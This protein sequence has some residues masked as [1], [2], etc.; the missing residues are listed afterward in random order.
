M[1]LSF[2]QRVACRV[3][4]AALHAYECPRQRQCETAFRRLGRAKKSAFWSGEARS[5]QPPVRGI[6]TGAGRLRWWSGLANRYRRRKREVPPQ[7]LGNGV[8]LQRKGTSF[9]DI[10]QEVPRGRKIYRAARVVRMGVDVDCMHYETVPTFGMFGDKKC[11]GVL[12]VCRPP[13]RKVRPK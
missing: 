12:P 6:R 4:I 9:E 10:P 11:E 13:E 2:N 3:V 1:Q 5:V 8:V 7:L